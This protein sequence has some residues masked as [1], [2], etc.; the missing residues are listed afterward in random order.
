MTT[1]RIFFEKQGEAAYVS[2]LDLQ[3]VFHRA[4]KRSGLPVWYTEG[5]N[6]HIYLAFCSPLPLG[7]ESVCESCDVKTA[8]E[9]PYGAAWA[10]A[11]Q[12]CMPGGIT[13]TGAAAAVHKAGEV[14]AARYAITLPAAAAPALA[15]YN[16][17]GSVPAEKK[18]KRGARVVELKAAVPALS[19][20]G[21]G[22]T[23]RL[24]TT[25][26]CASDGENLNPAL[27]LGALQTLAGEA[28][29]AFAPWQCRILRT[30]LLLPDG[31]PFC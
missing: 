26:P 21:R 6:P 17:A 2:L 25:L 13:V 27:L 14:A 30:A 22:D 31:T 12:P 3:R 7:Q 5:F 8:A 9:P 28:G 10:A 15:A 18:T 24:E 29:A 16:A 20:Q 1:V 19:W 11:L 23:L 4:L